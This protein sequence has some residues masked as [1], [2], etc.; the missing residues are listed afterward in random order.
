MRNFKLTTLSTL[1][2]SAGLCSLPATLLAQEVVKDA[3]APKQEKI[4]EVIVT[5]SRRAERLQDVPLSVTAASA[6]VLANAG[7][8]NVTEL[9]NA[10]SGITYG[11]SPG[12]Q[13]FHIRGAGQMGGFSSASE[14]PVGVVVDGVVYG[15]G[16]GVDN[17]GDIERV[18]VLKGPQ[19]TQFG[20]N[21]SSGAISITTP[22]PSFERLQGDAFLSFGNDSERELRTTLNV[23]MSDTVAAR[24]SLYERKHDGFI[25]NV[26]RHERWG[27]ETQKGVRAKLLF[28]PSDAFDALV[29]ADSSTARSKGPMQTWTLR[30]APPALQSGYPISG[31]PMGDVIPAGVIP[32]PDNDKSIEDAPGQVDIKR[33]GI[34]LE[35]NY[36][37]NGYTLTSVSAYR[38]DR[39]TSIFA[40]DATPYDTNR[41]ANDVDKS[42]TTQELRVTSPK[43][44]LLEY[45]AGYYY[46]K[47]PS[48]VVKNTYLRP[49]LPFS[50]LFV[51]LS[52]GIATSRTDSVSHAIFADGKLRISSDGHTKALFGVRF[53]RDQVDASTSSVIDPSL[54]PAITAP[55]QPNQLTFGETAK[56]GVSGRL[57]LEHRVDKDL[58]LYGTVATGYLGPTVTFSDL[59]NTR[60]NVRPQKVSDVTL[61]F[62]AQFL[63][64]WVTINGSIFSDKYTDL[65][66]AVF[67]KGEFLTE[68]AGGARSRGVE[69]DLSAR[70]N[71]SV[72]LRGSLTY[73]DAVFTDYRTDCPAEASA[74]VCSGPVV[75][76]RPTQLQAAGMSLPG[77]PKLTS[78]L[79]ADYSAE[80]GEDHNVIASANYSYRSKAEYTPGVPAHSQAAYGVLNLSAQ[81]GRSDDKWRVGVYVRNAMNERYKSAII[82][83]PFAKEGGM[84][85]WMTYEGSRHIGATLE[86]R[87]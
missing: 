26:V 48:H 35:M 76:G 2:L 41:V 87:F 67:R 32:G 45:V 58:L 11:S 42:Q 75:N 78:T 28:K 52:N 66:T 14:T 70:L 63:N 5:A 61:G 57:G 22:R 15:L 50:P 85:N 1:L 84:V 20:K 83:L 79:G 53:N 21:A 72:R 9:G 86:L 25:D 17:L 73:A 23:P 38:K 18:E 44:Q 34:S 3:P 65:Q 59:T 55:Y 12:D 4:Q 36:A 80:V 49:A 43:G 47:Q 81:Y 8:K 37:V 40:I 39:N 54:N 27:G 24:V 16:Q 29:I 71:T 56:T 46:Y 62:K 30:N 77:S 6:Q 74:S 64:R 51:S 7:V 68:N 19:G 13:G 60:S 33:S 69:M 31:G 82:G 10:M